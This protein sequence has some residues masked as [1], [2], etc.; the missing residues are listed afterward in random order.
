M[1]PTVSSV[2]LVVLLAFLA[3]LATSCDSG[4]PRQSSTYTRTSSSTEVSYDVEWPAH[5]EAYVMRM[6]KRDFEGARSVRVTCGTFFMR[7][8]GT[9]EATWRTPE[10]G[11]CN[12]SVKLGLSAPNTFDPSRTHGM[13]SCTGGMKSDFAFDSAASSP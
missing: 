11:Y 2:R 12:A 7:S 4:E 9:C 13:G 5:G 3:L 10:G 1:A 6:I 8:G